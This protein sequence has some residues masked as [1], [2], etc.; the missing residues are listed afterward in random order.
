MSANLPVVVI[1]GSSSGFGRLFADKFA[2]N[3][4]SVFA[5][6]RGVNGKNARSAENLRAFAAQNALPI[7]VMEMDV[8]DEESVNTCVGGVVSKAGRIDVL[9]TNAGFAYV[10]LMETI[11]TEQTQSIFETSACASQR[12][13]RA[14]LPEM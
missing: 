13:R 9:I 14:P 5:T 7:E 4:Y 2:R 8:T 1:T 3:G 6:M 12:T 11:T 10:D